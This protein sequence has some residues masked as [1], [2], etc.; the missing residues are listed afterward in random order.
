MKENTGQVLVQVPADIANFLLNEKR[1]A[2]IEIE[3]RQEASIIVVADD[4]LDTPHYEVRRLRASEVALETAP[5]YERVTPVVATALPTSTQPTEPGEQPAVTRITP[6]AP[7]PM[8]EEPV[9]AP[10]A[11]AAAPVVVAAPQRAGFFKR[12]WDSMFG[13]GEPAAVAV[14]APSSKP[15]HA[16]DGQ[17][18][19]QGKGAH[20]Q[21]RRDERKPHG[22]RP[23]GQRGERGERGE[24]GDRPQQQ[25]SQQKD[26]GAQ[27]PQGAAK[28]R[29]D[30][31]P[32]NDASR[33]QQQQQQGQAQKPR[34]E[35]QPKQDRPDRQE[36]RT[37]RAQQNA[38]PAAASA[39]LAASGSSTPAAPLTVGTTDSEQRAA[40][41]VIAAL[42]ASDAATTLGNEQTDVGGDAKRRRGR[43]GGRRRR[44]GEREGSAAGE[45]TELGADAQIDLEDEDD[46]DLNGNEST[47]LDAVPAD[48][49]QRSW[50]NTG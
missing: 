32:R 33:P 10:A 4:K 44:R 19:Q 39:A 48:I 31:G 11:V 50:V 34:Q 43:R 28:D 18:P 47:H 20:G 7:V 12:I 26:R 37:D 23:D 49:H 24:R 2:I 25:Q 13:S 46:H 35:Q 5:S 22:G 21:S 9:T 1:S 29:P 27:Q 36:P 15:A 30:R 38:K 3:K 6:V 42:V 45:Q 14:A 16:R 40:A 8:R 17:R 41:S